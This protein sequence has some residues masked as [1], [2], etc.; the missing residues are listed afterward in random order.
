MSY[1]NFPQELR[2]SLAIGQNVSLFTLVSVIQSLHRINYSYIQERSNG[3]ALLNGMHIL[4][5]FV[6][7]NRRFP[8]DAS[9]VDLGDPVYAAYLTSLRALLSFR[10]SSKQAGAA[11]SSSS[12]ATPSYVEDAEFSKAVLNFQNVLKSFMNSLRSQHA[13]MNRTSFES[14]H[15]LTWVDQAP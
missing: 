4:H 1:T 9:I 2:L 7:V 5:D 15:A 11:V 3:L 10:E 13:V 8:A 14:T 6:S 12:S